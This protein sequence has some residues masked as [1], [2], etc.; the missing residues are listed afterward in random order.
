M[1]HRS[2]FVVR[3]VRAQP[4]LFS[5]GPRDLDHRGARALYPLAGGDQRAHRLGHRRLDLSGTRVFMIAC[6]DVESIRRRAAD[7]DEGGWPSWC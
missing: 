6:S 3:I 2:L 5:S 4:R 1:I 7:Q